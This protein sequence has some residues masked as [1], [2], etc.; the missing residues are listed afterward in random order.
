MSK[1]YLS[2][3]VAI[4]EIM[5][6]LLF[7][8][9]YLKQTKDGGGTGHIRLIKEHDTG[10]LRFTREYVVYID[11]ENTHTVMKFVYDKRNDWAD[12]QVSAYG[13]INL[14]LKHLIGGTKDEGIQVADIKG[15]QELCTQ[16]EGIR[17]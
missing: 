2:G 10:S 12:I 4:I 16:N 6:K 9:G 14:K 3:Q 7:N 15:S 13:L 5:E 8:A 17:G 1:E 11:G